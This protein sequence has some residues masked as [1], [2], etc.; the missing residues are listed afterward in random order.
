[1]P[2]LIIYRTLIRRIWQIKADKK[3]VKGKV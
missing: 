3:I 1:L 2:E